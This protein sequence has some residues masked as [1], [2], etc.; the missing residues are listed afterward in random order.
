[1]KVL[2]Y[3]FL[4]VISLLAMGTACGD[5]GDMNVNPNEPTDVPAETLVTQG[6]FAV[7][8][9]YWDRDYNF[10]LGTLFAQHFA[11]N[12]YTE[13]QR[14]VF[15][16]SDF[17]YEWAAL[18]AGGYATDQSQDGGLADLRAAR[19]L[20]VADESLPD[21]QRANQLAV[22]DIMESFAFMFG[23]DLW[24]DMPYSQALNPE[25][26]FQPAYDSQG[27]IYSGMISKVSSAVSS[28]N[29]NADGFS[30]TADIIMNGNMDMWQKFGNALLLRMG[31]RIADAN[32]TLAAQTVA[33]AL[34][35][36]IIS[37]VDDEAKLV[38]INSPFIANPFWYDTNIDNRDDFRIT[39]ELLDPMISMNDP[40]IPMYADETP[41]GGYVGMPYGLEDG[42]AFILKNSTS[43]YGA[44]LRDATAPAY[45]MRYSE[46]KFLE[47]EAIKRGFINGGSA[48][49]E[50]AFNAAVTAS[51]NEWGITDATVIGDYL[52]NNSYD[53][54]N[55]KNSIAFQLWISLYGNG[56]EAWSSWRRLDYPDLQV[57]DA[58]YIDVIPL[59]GLYPTTEQSTNSANLGSV[60]YEDKMETRL[61][62]DVD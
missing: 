61:W 47:A 59:R 52:A 8:Y 10:E 44:M 9:L 26:Y 40:R 50:A 29:V 12:E 19:T 25:E 56:M 53:D 20:I 16:N 48:E 22:L 5:F 57:P 18:F 33:T 15:S 13:E 17:N 1:M 46:V 54:A 32:A 3:K 41:Q 62:W 45:L 6:Q 7:V 27:E 11:Q 38:F 34:G 36:N 24:G 23:T 58:A 37:S 39:A 43:N 51:M 55:W 14:Y 35:G 31:M 60:A 49:A 30:S 21:D 42:D 28:I 2:S 4:L